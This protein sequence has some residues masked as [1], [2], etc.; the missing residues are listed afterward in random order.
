MDPHELR[1]SAFVG[2]ENELGLLEAELAEAAAGRG[3]L[4]TVAGDAGIGKTRLVEEFVAR[5]PIP[6]HRVV[7]GPCPEQPGAPAYW[8]WQQAIRAYAHGCEAGVLATELGS[9]APEIARLVPALR[10]HLPALDAPATVE[11]EEWRF[12]LFDALATFLR[13]ATERTPLVIVLDDL[14]W[15]DPASLQLLAFLG[16]ELRGMRLFLLGTYRALELE[17]RPGLI[18]GLA[19]ANR[20]VKLRGLD[21]DHVRQ[22]MQMTSG[23]APAPGLVDDVHRITEGNPFFLGELVR[24]LEAEGRLE[25]LDLASLP[26]KLPAELRATIRRRLGPLADEERRL[27]ELA[28]VI[29]RE[30]DVGV[31]QVACE[32]PRDRV[33]ELLGAAIA[34]RL[35]DER[36]TALGR[37][38]FA[39]A[40]IR[41]TLYEE[42]AP[43]T[44][45]QLHRRIGRAL[46]ALSAGSLDR[47]YAQ[48]A[49]HFFR[50]ATL[51]DAATALEYAERA[52]HQAGAQFGYEEAV[53]HF[54][55]ATQLLD[56]L[57]ADGPRRVALELALGTA[58]LRASDTRKARATFE[59][60]AHDAASLGDSEALAQ[61]ALGYQE[62]RAPMG[63]ID[64]TEV[65]LLEAALDGLGPADS[66]L[67]ARVVLGLG[68][69]L[70][71]E[72]D[73]GRQRALLAEAL[74]IARRVGD[75][76][77]LATALHAQHFRLLGPT[78][79]RERIAI[80][81]E[82]I[83]LAERA[84]AGTVAFASRTS[85]VHDL[86][87]SC[88][89]VSAEREIEVLARD[90][91][92]TRL[93]LH[94]WIVAVL[95]A[96]LAISSGRVEEGARLSAQALELRRDGQ[97]PAV[98]MT[99]CGQ[100]FVARR[101]I[102]ALGESLEQSMAAF[103]DS[104]PGMHSWPCTLVVA[105]AEAERMDAARAL[106]ERLGANGFA[107]VPRDVH[108]FPALAMLA[109]AVHLL[110][111]SARA[112]QLYPLL[113]PYADRNVVA[114]WWSP[115]H[116]GSV[117]R[118][119]GL[120]AATAGRP[121]EAAG[122]FEQA[123]RAN[124]AMGTRGQLA[125]T[126]ADHARLLFA[127]NRPGDGEHALRLVA[128]ARTAAEE[129]GLMRLRE[130][131]AQLTPP[132]LPA[133]REAPAAQ[134]AT[135]R[136]EGEHWRVGLGAHTVQLKDG[137][138]L[139]YLA[140]LVREPG[141]EFHVL[142]LATAGDGS[143]GAARQAHAGDAGE[144]LDASALAA[145]KC[146]LVDLENELEEAGRFNDP[147]RVD[148]ARQEA[149]FLH[150]ELARAVGL[151]G[152]TRRAGAASERARVSVTKMLGRTIDK[153]AASDP[154]LG[155][156]LAAAVRRGL[157]CCYAPD[158][159]LV[160][161]WQF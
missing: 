150:A 130:R 116:V 59:R 27:L 100:M 113:R 61:A 39:H 104:Y 125:H 60:A 132:L 96:S 133:E 5:A 107:D 135:L 118:Y 112:E 111:D 3:R 35:V 15:A 95:R 154:A 49:H 1:G 58:A 106:L 102:G 131:I 56:L 9:S 142:D 73:P 67:R 7:W 91:E 63:V 152:R 80:I 48:L 64:P 120:L 92:Q 147:G 74:A 14:H 82:A 98:L 99:H 86:L 155:Q 45:G 159:R 69:A 110:D 151:H 50:A 12:R 157:Y 115:T 97:D 38:R 72:A 85:L 153:I 24:M 19:R 44:R 11:S 10:E 138:G 103:A 149:E 32:L 144:L 13:R 23:V 25:S 2:R 57:P 119:L 81:T 16:R 78:D 158:P 75:A 108:F 30:F 43:A 55:R 129:L 145:Y 87:E 34:A 66:A 8:P 21:R 124:A 79:L 51:G 36:L 109:E 94:R 42:L 140:T 83:D 37:G 89:I 31:L 68:R 160:L 143:A 126:K 53:A 71:Y 4:I 29:G 26:M 88:D 77:A 141:R 6:S 93:P 52:G 41:E 70:L 156:H 137:R 127:R 105:H 65:R 139:A 33:L 22:I 40:L 17:V 76:Q 122:H 128:E 101:E 134:S 121:D 20:R 18:E 90:A 148:R 54:E 46:E 62:A 84:H 114:S 136:R 161:R 123:Q 146:R 47:P 117:A 28:A